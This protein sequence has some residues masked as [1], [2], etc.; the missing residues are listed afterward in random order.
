[1]R[2]LCFRAMPLLYPRRG[3]YTRVRMTRGRKISHARRQRGVEKLIGAPGPGVKVCRSSS[4]KRGVRIS[5]RVL[6]SIPSLGSCT[7]SPSS[8]A[9]VFPTRV[10]ARDILCSRLT[11]AIRPQLRARCT[12]RAWD[13]LCSLTLPGRGYALYRKPTFVLLPSVA[14]TIE[15]PGTTRTVF[16]TAMTLLLVPSS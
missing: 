16:A 4:D 13:I 7:W 12:S 2:D 5:E 14:L 9:A 8:T 15:V 6:G 11:V 1:M 10:R 3:P